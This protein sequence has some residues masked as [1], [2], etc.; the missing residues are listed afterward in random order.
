MFE[1]YSQ[2]YSSC[3]LRLDFREA[4]TEVGRSVRKPLL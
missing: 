3:V 1:G 2:G 4:K